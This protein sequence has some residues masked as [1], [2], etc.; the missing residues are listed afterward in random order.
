MDT[1]EFKSLDDPPPVAAENHV[2]K[3]H[4]DEE[5][6]RLDM[7]FAAHVMCAQKDYERVS[8]AVSKIFSQGRKHGFPTQMK[9]TMIPNTASPCFTSA[10]DPRALGMSELYREQQRNLSR[11]LVPI[12]VTGMSYDIHKQEEGKLPLTLHAAV[13][14]LSHPD[15]S[16]RII[17]SFN[18]VRQ[19]N[20]DEH[21]IMVKK[22][23]RSTAQAMI[24]RIGLIM[25]RV[26]GPALWDVWFTAAYRI[27]QKTSFTYNAQTD[28]YRSHEIQEVIK[29]QQ[30]QIFTQQYSQHPDFKSLISKF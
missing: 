8:K 9:Y 23:I 1:T 4:P 10:L 2:I 28:E 16:G 25:A 29:L 20:K 17:H 19:G 18:K 21:V 26:F 30:T 7:V 13:L 6:D 3:L 12:N 11:D 27:Q 24:A 15:H 14:S 22:S 5:I